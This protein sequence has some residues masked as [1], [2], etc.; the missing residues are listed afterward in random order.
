MAVSTFIANA[1]WLMNSRPLESD[2]VLHMA[3]WVIRYGTNPVRYDSDMPF[4]G[5]WVDKMIVHGLLRNSQNMA[6]LY[7]FVVI[8]PKGM[9]YLKGAI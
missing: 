3:E 6:S 2:D 8:T 7:D 9:N 4:D 1:H 5:H